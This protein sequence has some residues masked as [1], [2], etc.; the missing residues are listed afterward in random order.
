MPTTGLEA[1]DTTVQKMHGWLASIEGCLPGSSRH[2]A[3]AGLR[4]VLHALRDRLSPDEAAHFGAQ[5]PMLIR[6]LFY[7]GWHPAGK[8]LRV[9]SVEEFLAHV[10]KELPPDM[11]RDSE[12]ITRAV[13]R[14]IEQHV[15]AGETDKVVGAMPRALREL[16]QPSPEDRDS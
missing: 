2:Q 11:Q 16:W 8:P 4:A 9:R 14:V 6:G 13:F 1:I 3:Y 10:E 12:D 7:E 5:L 15:D